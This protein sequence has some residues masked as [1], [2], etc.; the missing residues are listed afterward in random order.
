MRRVL[1]LLLTIIFTLTMFFIAIGCKEE[2]VPEEKAIQEETTE[3]VSEETIEEEEVQTITFWNSGGTSDKAA[4]NW[5]PLFE[6]KYP[7]IKIEYEVFEHEA[8]KEL[9]IAGLASGEAGDIN[10]ALGGPKFIAKFAEEGTLRVLDDF[11]D[12]HKDYYNMKYAEDM[13]KQPDGHYYYAGCWGITFPNIFYNIDIFEELNLTIPETIDDLYEI[14]DV[15]RENG[16][17]SISLNTQVPN[18]GSHF[19]SGALLPRFISVGEANEILNSWK[20][21]YTGIKWTDPRIIEAFE[22]WRDLIDKEVFVPDMPALG[23]D[24]AAALFVN[25]KAAMFSGG[26]WEGG[27]ALLGSQITDFEWDSF[28]FPVVDEQYPLT[29]QYSINDGWIVKEDIE[30]P[31]AVNKLLDFSISKEVQTIIMQE[32]VGPVRTDIT[33]EEMEQVVNKQSANIWNRFNDYPHNDSLQIWLHEGVT[34]PYLRMIN[35]FISG[36]ITAEEFCQEMEQLAE[37]LRQQ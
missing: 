36:E 20:P 35:P 9:L 30:Y 14:S 4:K 7:N 26:C 22:L 13:F 15:L 18:Y 19:I 23:H 17:M 34:E 31:D 10:Y 24:E 37:E 33:L 12:R 11:Y 27:D 29:A 16:Y 8:F 3:E 2:T 28:L 32:G 6:E 25:Q 5:L 21:G 1:I